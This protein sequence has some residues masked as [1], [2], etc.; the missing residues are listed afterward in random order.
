MSKQIFSDECDGCRPVAVDLETGKIQPDDSPIMKSIN[1]VWA[2]T[3]LEE[4]QAFHRVTCLNSRDRKDLQIMQE[5]TDKVT[6]V[7]W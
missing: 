7:K 6:K 5:F 3:T 2:Q 1:K 4:R